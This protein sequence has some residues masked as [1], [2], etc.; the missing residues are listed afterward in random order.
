METLCRCLQFHHYHVH[1]LVRETDPSKERF[2][3]YRTAAAL[4][5]VGIEV[6]NADH[7]VQ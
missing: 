4:I 5:E 1:K 7:V 2:E 3:S 6:L